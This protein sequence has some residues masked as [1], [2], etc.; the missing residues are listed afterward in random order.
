MLPSLVGLSVDQ[1]N[2]FVDNICASFLLPGCITA[3]YYSNRVMQLPLA[4]FGLAFAA[5]SLPAMSK[6]YAQKDITTLKNSLNYSVRFTNFT[7]LPAVA[8]LMTIGLPIIK[9][10]FEHGK[11]TSAASIMTNNALFYYS[12]GLP[13]YATA[14]IFANAF[15]SFQDTKTPVKTAIWAMLLHMGLCILLMRPM[16]VGGLALATALSSYFNFILLVIYLRKHIGNFGLKQII[17]SSCKS[18]IAS[19]ATAIVAWNACKVSDNLFISVP[20]TILLGILTFVVCAYI[21]RS[22][23]LKIVKGMFV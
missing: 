12:L 14:K 22:E 4:I 23:E 21:L 3:L 10:L 20:S 16:G 9:I 17:F 6:A 15:Y 5:V 1:I 11:F 8:G 2:A 13:A 19:I 7:L 18:L